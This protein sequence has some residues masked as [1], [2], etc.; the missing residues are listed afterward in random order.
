MG[1]LFNGKK[2]SEDKKRKAFYYTCF[3]VFCCIAINH[4]DTLLISDAELTSG[5]FF[6]L[7]LFKYTPVVVTSALCGSIP[8]LFSVMIVFWYKTITFSSFAYMT[9]IYMLVAMITHQLSKAGFFRNLWKTCIATLYFQIVIGVFW[10]MILGL[11][12]GRTL[13]DV[14]PEKAITYF[15]SELPAALL[16]M[17]GVY[18]LM[19][20]IPDKELVCLSNGPYYLREGRKD[21]NRKAK[22]KIGSIV[23]NIILI[24]ALI[25][26]LCA[27]VASM[28][29][30]PAIREEKAE[31][32]D[33]TKIQVEEPDMS[34]R[35]ISNTIMLEKK[36][37]QI[38]KVDSRIEFQDKKDNLVFEIKMFMLILIII[39]P[40]AVIINF[41]AQLRLGKPII[42]LSDAVRAIFGKGDIV[43]YDRIDTLHELAINTGDEIENLYEAIDEAAYKLSDY[44]AVIRNQ[45]QM[46]NELAIANE[47][48][49]AKTRFLSNMSHEIRTPINAILGFDEMILR[50]SRERDTITYAKNIQNSGKTLLSLINEILDFSKIEAGKMEIIPVE[51][52]I[53]SMIVDVI[54][55]IKFR[56]EA[57][58]LKFGVMVD[59]KIPHMLVGDEIRIKQCLINL[60]TNAVKYTEKGN[61]SLEISFKNVD[62]KNIELFFKISDT[63]IGIKEEDLEK[64]FSQFE[65]LEEEKNRTIEGTGLGMNIVKQLLSMM[66]TYLEVESQYGVGSTFSFK[67]LQPVVSWDK[68]GSIAQA[69]EETLENTSSYREEF[70]APDAKILVVDDT[71]TNLLVMQGLLKQTQIQIDLAGSGQEALEKCAKKKYNIIFMDHR[72]PNMDG[73]E[74]KHALDEMPDNPNAK[75]PVISLTANAIAGSREMY[76]AEGFAD[77]LT[78]PV[79]SLKLENMI[80]K[81]L[82]ANL[83]SHSG[84][85]DFVAEAGADEVDLEEALAYSELINIQGINADLAVENCGSSVFAKNVCIDFLRAIDD[86]A[87]R[88]EKYFN[89]KD[90]EAYTI[91]VHGLKSSSRAIGAA[92]LSDFAAFLEKC[93]DER[94]VDKIEKGTPEL[95]ALYKEYK[96]YLSPLLKEEDSDKPM[97]TPE[98][99]ENAF[100]SIKEL[101]EAS[102]F[103]SADDIMK[104]LENYKIPEEHVQKVEQIKK[105]MSAVDRDGLL[106]IL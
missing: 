80:L 82:P 61:I 74:T 64:L 89:E 76:I 60:L 104:M 78:K 3:I 31:N 51:Y 66:G 35:D 69:Y 47:A 7:S 1:V 34:W 95:L 100:A 103:D 101:V 73:V 12:V 96:D 93:G 102:F 17:F 10:C 23:T 49:Q 36:V 84:D 9:F 15:V 52:E 98:E 43:R 90:Y 85:R 22:S 106:N 24:E 6:M 81:Y 44:I 48:N 94:R 57:K 71:H 58:K 92:E 79:D 16:N 65:R 21:F 86:K 41:Y 5:Q 62:N 13:T 63:G 97:I 29:I 70:H 4:F 55:M 20:L 56:A 91:E 11:M 68:M 59:E 45:R 25:L 72:M 8:A 19:R 42:D 33:I 27:E 38:V 32:V 46:E 75:T 40:L 2:W 39:L 87:E 18:T 14:P 67:L 37:G 50:E 30:V 105:M 53:S 99:L 77:Y 83:V 54:N 26:G 28:T 88:I